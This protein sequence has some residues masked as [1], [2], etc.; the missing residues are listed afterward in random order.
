MKIKQN[1]SLP[2]MNLFLRLK[3]SKHI[4]AHQSI[5]EAKAKVKEGRCRPGEDHQVLGN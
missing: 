5:A 1:A 4:K 3:K 2:L